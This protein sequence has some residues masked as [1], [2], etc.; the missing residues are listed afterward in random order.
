MIVRLSATTSA[1][2]VSYLSVF[3]MPMFR[4]YYSNANKYLLIDSRNTYSYK[5]L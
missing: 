5:Y 2:L 1:S 3:S 4:A